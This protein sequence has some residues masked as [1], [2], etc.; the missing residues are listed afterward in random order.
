MLKNG[1]DNVTAVIQSIDTI[2]WYENGPQIQEALEYLSKAEG[3]LRK[4][5]REV[6]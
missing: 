6:N 3:I 5:A 4:T 1:A 2:A